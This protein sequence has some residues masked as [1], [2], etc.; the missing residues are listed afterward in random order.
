MAPC[1]AEMVQ[2]LLQVRPAGNGFVYRA[3]FAE[4]AHIIPD[5]AELRGKRFPKVI[6]HPAIE[7]CCMRQ[8]KGKTIASGIVMDL[9]ISQI[10]ISMICLNHFAYPFV[11]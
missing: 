4:T 7:K 3:G 8:K 10:K 2:K 6:E 9:P 1:D 5:Q 11:F